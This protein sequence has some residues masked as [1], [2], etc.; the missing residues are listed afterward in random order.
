VCFSIVGGVTFVVASSDVLLNTAV[1]VT[2]AAHLI[3]SHLK[4]SVAIVLRKSDGEAI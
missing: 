3:I 2:G 1:W 4:L